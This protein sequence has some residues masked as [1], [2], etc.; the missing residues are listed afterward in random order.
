M[1]HCNFS[2]L[3]IYHYNSSIPNHTITIPT[4]SEI[5]HYIPFRQ[6][7]QKFWTKLPPSSSLL[8]FIQVSRPTA[9]RPRAPR[10]REVRAAFCA[11]REVRTPLRRE[12][13]A[14]PKPCGGEHDERWRH[15][16]QEE[17]R[18]GAP[19]SS[20][21]DGP[22]A[23][24]RSRPSSSRSGAGE[25]EAASALALLRPLVPS[26]GLCFAPTSL[27]LAW[28]GR[29]GGHVGHGR[30]AEAVVVLQSTDPSELLAADRRSPCSNPRIRRSSSR[31]IEG[32][33]A[34]PA[35]EGRTGR[36]RDSGGIPLPTRPRRP[37]K[38]APPALRRPSE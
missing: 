26:S 13:R 3:E 37:P 15:G 19:F 12:L 22:M 16:E 11:G 29:R 1:Y 24:R 32:H 21:P 20:A 18:V 38:L 10:G 31:R 35:T 30:G 6:V 2:K 14:P 34:S 7:S 5:Y 9:P 4:L 25:F 8:S 23:R 27:C 36:E 28:P 33:R 17:L